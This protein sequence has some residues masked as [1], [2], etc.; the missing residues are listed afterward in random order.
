MLRFNF[1]KNGATV[2]K[3]DINENTLY[4]LSRELKDN[5]KKVIIKKI[6][7]VKIA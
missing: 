2:V 1:L 7:Y 3:V 4:Q 5:N 6:L